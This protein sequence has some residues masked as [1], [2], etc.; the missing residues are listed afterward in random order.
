MTRGRN[1]F[2]PTADLE[3]TSSWQDWLLNHGVVNEKADGTFNFNRNQEAPAPG[4]GFRQSTRLQESSTTA[5]PS[6]SQTVLMP[7]TDDLVE[8]LLASQHTMPSWKAWQREGM[9]WEGTAEEKYVENVGVKEE[10]E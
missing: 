3:V 9:D 4:H 8:E 6:G 1:F 7:P 5:G 2:Q 10:A